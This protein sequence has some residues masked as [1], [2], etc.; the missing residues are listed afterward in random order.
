MSEQTTQSM[1][2]RIVAVED[3]PGDVRLT[4]EGVETVEKNVE[5]RV[6]NNGTETIEWLTDGDDAEPA[7]EIGLLLI[8]LNLP[9]SSGFEILEAIRDEPS[10]SDVPTVV[11]S[12]SENRDDVRRAYELSANSYITKPVDPD[13]YIQTIGAATRFWID[14]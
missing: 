12:S 10:L 9:G 7:E 4:E 2:V 5:L 13:E 3:N 11:V 14:T 8:D 6:L 1:P